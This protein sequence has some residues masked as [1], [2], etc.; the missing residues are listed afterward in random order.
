MLGAFKKMFINQTEKVKSKEK[1][2]VSMPMFQGDK[3][4][5]LDAVGEVLKQHWKLNVKDIEGDDTLAIL[6]IED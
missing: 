1:V 3:A 2:L 4:Y 5:S 6:T